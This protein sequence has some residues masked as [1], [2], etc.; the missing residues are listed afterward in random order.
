MAKSYGVHVS[1]SAKA[2]VPHVKMP[3]A[4]RASAG[5]SRTGGGGAYPVYEGSH[6]QH[7][8][9]ARHHNP[10]AKPGPGFTLHKKFSF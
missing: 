1:A 4:P 3:S 6:K 5:H 10:V 2:P 7:P 8:G 9:S